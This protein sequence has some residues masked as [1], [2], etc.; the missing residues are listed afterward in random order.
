MSLRRLQAALPDLAA[1]ARARAGEFEAA[2]R[3]A[4][5]FA[6]KLKRCSAFR[7]LVPTEAGGLGASLPQWFE[8]MTALA[9]ADA[10]T[11]WVT[12]HANITAGLIHASAEPRFGAEFFAD[13]LA[14]AAWSNLPKVEAKEEETG[15]RISGSWGFES[16]C[17]EATFVGG[18]VMLPPLAEGKPPRMV[19]ALAPVAEATIEETW[20]PVGLAGTGS[21]DVRFDDVLVPWH[22]TFPWPAGISVASYPAGIFAPGTWFVSTGT[23]ATHLGLARRA[24][25]EARGLL[26]GKVDRF[27]GRPV[28]EHPATQRD[29]ESAEGLWFAC[30][31][32]MR[33]ALAAIW[34]SAER[35]EPA[36]TEMRLDI[37]VATATAVQRGAEI[38]RTAYDLSGAGAIH[39]GGIMQRLLRD[40][41]CLTHHA[42]ANRTAYELTGR[43]RCGFDRLSFRI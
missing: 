3:L 7:V 37:R 12:G 36:T 22:R 1:E 21:H 16:G 35:G 8:L 38:V 2:R 13:P 6:L 42:S 25:D 4:P 15:L 31:A 10:S 43:V 29:L 5:D 17:T 19:A 26:R 40:A 23:A 20:D 41:S 39:R 28:L 33:E 9:E 18:M 34:R 14:F 30:R 11:G 27:T 24:L 32:G